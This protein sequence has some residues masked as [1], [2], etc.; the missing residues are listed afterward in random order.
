MKRAGRRLVWARYLSIALGRW[1]GKGRRRRS[2]TV[3]VACR[4]SDG[5]C[6]QL[7]CSGS[8][9]DG[10]DRSPE[11]TGKGGTTGPPGDRRQKVSGAGHSCG[12]WGNSGSVEVPSACGTSSR[13]VSVSEATSRCGVVG[14][15]FCSSSMHTT[16]RMVSRS[17][18][19]KKKPVPDCL[20]D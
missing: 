3:R 4:A 17:V 20:R 14:K 18:P 19:E 1:P 6:D 10:G 7:L 2:L 9:A 13:I 8:T 12:S 15:T 16:A 5:I 11:A